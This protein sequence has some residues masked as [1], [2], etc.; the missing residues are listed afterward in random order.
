MA[1]AIAALTLALVAPALAA[2]TTWGENGRIVFSSYADIYTVEPDG[3]DLTQVVRDLEDEKRDWWP[4]WSPDG[5]RI[6][7]SGELFEPPSPPFG[8]RYWGDNDLQVFAPDGSGF[9]RL[10]TLNQHFSGLAAWSPD[11]SRIAYVT[12]WLGGG[13][14][15]TI[16]P[17]DGE[18][19]V[20]RKYANGPDYSDPAW[21]PD[22]SRIAFVSD[23]SDGGTD[24]F[25]MRADGTDVRKVV[26]RPGLEL[27]PSWSPDGST[28]VF[29]G[30]LPRH[31]TDLSWWFPRRDIYAV[32]AIGGAVVQLTEGGTDQ[33]P[34][35][36]PD[37]MLIAFQS[38][39][40]TPPAQT[41][42]DLYVMDADGGDETRITEIGCI[43][44]GPDWQPLPTDEPAPWPV[45]FWPYP[46]APPT[47]VEPPSWPPLTR[48]P[49][50]RSPRTPPRFPLPS[51]TTVR[52]PFV[53]IERLVVTP[54]AFRWRAVR[55]V[56]IGL[57]LS[58]ARRIRITV[59][60][61]STAVD[62]RRC[63]KKSSP[64]RASFSVVRKLAAGSNRLSLGAVAPSK[65]RFGRYR[66][67]VGPASGAPQRS[68]TF[69][70][71]R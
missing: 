41:A 12:D 65:L 66:L 56:Q 29:A 26:E 69:R 49:I 33:D 48:R 27:S 44:C 54:R 59:K 52:P 35:W 32:S 1:G 39:R 57:W 4:A 3:S 68:T 21:S 38:D 46:L 23:G 7:T 40:H 5:T 62:G 14:I 42:P 20:I 55:R 34:V 13:S 71:R 64:C 8:D 9:G 28:I 10:E 30:S 16:S 18:D 60:P 63:A 51:P 43:Q 31:G 58:R 61:V 17:E 15:H 53:W 2:A 25:T 22:G 19:V 45:P 36:S 11:G 50:L 47:A 70:V 6:V 24:L 67:E 37:G